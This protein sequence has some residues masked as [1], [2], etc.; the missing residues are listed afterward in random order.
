[1]SHDFVYG[2]K[3]DDGDKMSDSDLKFVMGIAVMAVLWGAFSYLWVNHSLNSY[4][5]TGMPV[6]TQ[7]S[8]GIIGTLSVASSSF[9]SSFPTIFTSQFV[10]INTFIWPVLLL[11]LL[12]VALRFIRGQ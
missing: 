3:G 10:L 5:G 6:Y 2:C 12:V 7:Q 8:G 11:G 1:M 4:Q 9:L